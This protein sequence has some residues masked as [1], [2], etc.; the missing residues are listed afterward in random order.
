L[1]ARTIECDLAKAFE[2]SAVATVEK[3]VFVFH[4]AEYKCIKV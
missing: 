4:E 3:C 1:R 2:F